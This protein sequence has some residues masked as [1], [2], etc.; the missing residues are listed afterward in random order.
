MVAAFVLWTDHVVRRRFDSVRWELPARVYSRALEIYPGLRMGMDGIIAEL[1]TLGYLEVARLSGPGQYARGPGR[2]SVFTRG[3]EFWDSTEPARAVVVEFAGDATARVQALERA[4]DVAVVRLEP[5]E[6][7]SIH[8]RR[9]ED[10]ILVRLEDVPLQLVDA[11]VAAEDKRFFEHHGVDWQAILRAGLANVRAG[12]IRQGGSTLTQQL[13]K[14]LYLGRERTL[15]R[16]L[17]EALMALILEWR[18]PKEAILE[19]YLNE[20]FLGQ[21]GN[22]AIHGFGLAARFYFARPLGELGAGELA[23][24]AGLARGASYYDPR[25]HADRALAR[26][27]QV[28]SLMAATGKLSERSA[29]LLSEAPLGLAKSN[30]DD[31]GYPAFMD[32]VRD[33]LRLEYSDADLGRT[34]LRIFTTFDPLVQAAAEAAVETGLPRL[35]RGRGLAP[36]SLQAALV[37]TAPGTAEV[38]AVVGDRRPRYAGFNRA[39]DARRPIGSLIKPAVYLTA[40]QDPGRYSVITPL[41]DAPFSWKDARGRVWTP[42][43]YDSRLHGRVSLRTAISQSYNLATVHLGMQLGYDALARTLGALGY[44]EEVPRL[45]S[46]FLGAIE[47]T[48]LQ[49]AGIYQTLASGGFK[50]PL[51]A[52]RNVLD[53]DGVPLQRYGLHIEQTVAPPQAYLM[54]YLLSVATTEGTARGV[55]E[56]LPGSIPLAGKTGTTNDLRDSWFAGYGEDLLLV[57][58]IGRDD[59]RPA[60]LSGAA[61]ALRI[62]LDVMRRLHPAPIAQAVPDGVEW[63]WLTADLGAT[64]EPGCPEALHVPLMTAQIPAQHVSCEAGERLQRGIM[65]SIRELLR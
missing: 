29:R 13:V 9:H 19:A 33:Q 2:L 30:R 15:P 32:L 62:W 37:A 47:M 17:H 41:E 48:P 27:N 42:Q 40:L 50:M 39:R 35:E 65:D 36:G 46:V 26:R 58:W 44:S 31:S 55:A 53:R 10:R 4:E 20:I 45:P 61:G 8:P 12:R 25:R 7:G 64:T 51:R 18:Y 59:N 56:A 63:R 23:L 3:F 1:D 14:N 54:N 5:V 52:I 22:R 38:L 21:D 57:A 6:I 11:V 16:K 49:V 28:L 60:G 24:L 43:N 34:G